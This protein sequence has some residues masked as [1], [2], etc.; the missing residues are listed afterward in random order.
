MDD[1]KPLYFTYESSRN[2]TFHGRDE[3]GYTRGEWRG[4]SDEEKARALEEFLF[5]LVDVY[6]DDDNDEDEDY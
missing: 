4:L 3:S 1:D 6:V 5:E 2:V